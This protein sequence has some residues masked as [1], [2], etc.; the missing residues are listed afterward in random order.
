VKIKLALD[1]AKERLASRS[2][3]ETPA[4]ESEVLLRHILGIDRVQLYL[5]LEKDLQ[6][7]DEVKFKQLVERRLLGEPLA[8]IIRR[9][10]FFG[11]DFYVDERVLI[12]RPESEHLV[13]EALKL[14]K[15]RPFLTVADIGTGSGAI[16]ISLAMHLLQVKVFA[17][18]ISSSALEVARLNSQRHGVQDRIVLLQGDLLDPL[19]EPVDII[20]ANLPYV[21]DADMAETAS[22]GYEPSLA[23]RAGERG[24]DQITRFSLKVKYKLRPGGCLLLEIGMGQSRDVRALLHGLFPS[25]EIEVIPDL[26]GID[27]VVK[28]LFND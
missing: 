15:E 11:L 10:E 19:T 23:L 1:G 27:R 26:G 7:N 28:M 20:I 13:E 8:Y 14:A 24:L 12:P 17:T 5:D 16:A 22:P 4:L 9:R 3:I 6:P 21:R 2:D 18:D 25:T